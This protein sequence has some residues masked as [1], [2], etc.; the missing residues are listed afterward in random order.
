MRF[1][2]DRRGQSVVVGTVILFGFLILALGIYQVQV[3]PTENANVEFEHSQAVEDDFSDL[4]NGIL[5]AGATGSTGSTQVRLGTRY[6]ARTFFVNPP[7]ASGSLS[8]EPTGAIRI[9]NA[10]VGDG[11]HPNAA[12]FWD[13][14]QTF[15]TRSLRY[16]ARYNEFRDAPELVYEHSVVAA[17]FDGAVLLRTG[18]TVVADDR[19]SL[20]A[21][22]GSASETGIAPQSVDPR[23][24]SASGTTVPLE[25]TGGN[26]TLKL[27]TAVENA[28]ALAARWNRALPATAT[29]TPN[30]TGDALEIT[31]DNGSDPYRLALSEV[32][33]DATGTTE[34]AYIV[35]VGSETAAVGESVG[36]EVRDRYNN[37]VP[38]AVVSFDGENRT[39]G[40]DGRAFFEPTASGPL[41]ATINGTAGPTYES[42]SF[43]VSAGGGG[44]AGNRINVEWLEN[45]TV[46]I[47]P[48][49]RDLRILVTDSETGDP[50]EDAVVD[51]SYAERSATGAGPDDFVTASKTGDDG[52]TIAN[53]DPSAADTGDEFYLYATAGDDVDRIVGQIVDSGFNGFGPV[54][55]ADLTRQDT[56][57][58]EFQFEL[59]GSLAAGE[60]ISI[61]LDDPQDSTGTGNNFQVDY[62]GATGSATADGTVSVTAST[63]S[64]TAEF[65]ASSEIP[66]GTT[67]TVTLS[68][69]ETGNNGGQNDPYTVTF[70]RS[71]SGAAAETTFG[72]N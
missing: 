4:R 49:G 68:G 60:S 18:Q 45:E 22:T 41:T 61:N 31:L 53:F 26:V 62:Q 43:D 57:N 6:P 39:T 65:T 21:L 27:P 64:A 55:A 50:I 66:D 72:V 59:T 15:E 17:E 16:D 7:P 24:V 48:S 5:R 14:N 37:P 69:V 1:S 54:S 9:R 32:S 58:Q 2:R 36:V 19:I 25:P 70:T 42:V 44:A 51:A 8:T 35:S 10:T 3:V 11:A 29:A 38:D 33:L 28:S 34:P 46:Q 47:P 23:A 71:D 13:T 40:D 52:R 30:A 12:A 63:D 20:T 67:V 56:Q